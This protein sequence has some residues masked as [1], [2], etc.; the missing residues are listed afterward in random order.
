MASRLPSLQ[1]SRPSR[2]PHAKEFSARG[3]C[4]IDHSWEIVRGCSKDS[5][6]RASIP[7]S[8]GGVAWLARHTSCSSSMQP[9]MLSRHISPPT[10]RAAT[11]SG[12]VV[13]PPPDKIGLT[14][15][16]AH[17]RLAK[18][19]PNALPEQAPRPVWRR[20]V[21]QFESPLIYI[22]L[23]AL[24]FDLGVWVNEGGTG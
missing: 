10:F 23:F 24:A 11:R 3:A 17:E 20:F 16:E 1:R 6:A 18:V 9:V 14:T 13:Q 19:G 8:D 5:A 4:V 2:S 15:A 21:A 12:D 22:L 7:Q